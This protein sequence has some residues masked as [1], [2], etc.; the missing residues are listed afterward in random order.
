[1]ADSIINYCVRKAGLK[2]VLTSRKFLEKR[3]V[4]L[5]GAEWVFL[6]DLKEQITKFDKA[7]AALNAYVTPIPL[8]ERALGLTNVGMDDLLTI[9]F[10]SGSTGDPKGVMLS[11]GNIGSNVQ[12]V[13]H[14]LQLKP[15]DCLLGIL[16]FFHSFGYTATL[17]LPLCFDAS[18]VYHFNPLDAKIVG[19]LSEKYRVSIMLAA[20][21]FLRNYVKRCEKENF[22]ALHL[23]VTGAEKLPMELAEE[24]KAKF[25]FYP[26]EGYGTTEMSP[27]AA[28]NIPDHLARDAAYK[29]N[30]WER[31]GALSRA[32]RSRSLTP[33]RGPTSESIA[34]ACCLSKGPTS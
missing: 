6:E 9:V 25:G 20:P 28:V 26:S 1:M 14:L 4:A 24:F 15:N 33:T 29:S 12:A 21:T 13:D 11:Q 5:E 16:P 27:V 34:R 19:K 3:P 30:N 31:S 10:T 22:P 7:Q 18:A 23:V 32:A 17:W 8:L 2:H